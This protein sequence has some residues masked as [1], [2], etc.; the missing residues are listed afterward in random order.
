MY[1]DAVDTWALVLAA[2]EGTRLRALTTARSG[3][4]IPKQFC[5]LHEG[6]SLLHEALR[7]ARSV[8]AH[9]RTCAVVAE[10]HRPFWET[11]LGSLCPRNVIAQAENRGTGIGILLPLLHI[12]RRDPAA[13]VALLPSDH[14]VCNESVLSASLSD[15]MEQLRWRFNEVLLLG[16]EPEEPDPELGYIVPG[17]NDHRGAFMVER[18]IEKPTPAR[19]RELV[20]SGALWNAFIVAASG[21]AL[22]ELFRRRV[23]DLV[24]RL[25]VAVESDLRTPGGRRSTVELY[26]RLPNV[27]FSRDIVQGQE[28]QLRVLPVPRCGWSDLGT[29]RRVADALRR[30]PRP[31]LKQWVRAGTGYLS[32]ASQYE[33]LSGEHARRATAEVGAIW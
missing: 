7:R 24:E 14:H 22:L 2:G 29:P 28:E 4:A 32:L 23:P 18:F 30:A 26:Q 9:G 31:E 6:P 8:A 13:Q 3:T 17:A 33:R 21:Q 1:D 5:S 27:D 10:Q 19:T 15:A 12:L 25:R 11:Q 20:R 16:F